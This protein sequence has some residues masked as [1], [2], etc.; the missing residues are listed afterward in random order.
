M[1]SYGLD[2]RTHYLTSTMS[3][4]PLRIALRQTAG[5]TVWLVARKRPVGR[6]GP[7]W[8]HITMQGQAQRADT[9]SNVVRH[10][11]R[12]QPR[13]RTWPKSKTATVGIVAE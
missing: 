7:A 11:S 10:A 8:K 13:Q 3:S 12:T 6:G 9:A 1:R 4:R 2:T 5:S